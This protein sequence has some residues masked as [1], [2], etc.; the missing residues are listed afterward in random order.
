[1]EV[2]TDILSVLG[3][4]NESR[5]I[6]EEVYVAAVHMYYKMQ[7]CCDISPIVPLTDADKYTEKILELL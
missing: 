1:M 2:A 3:Q 4:M 7:K 5:V 6:P